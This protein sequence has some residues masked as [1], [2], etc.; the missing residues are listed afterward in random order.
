MNIKWLV[1]QQYKSF[2]N[3]SQPVKIAQIE[4]LE[5]RKPARAKVLKTDLV[6]IKYDDE[7]SV[8]YGR[9]LHRWVLLS[10]G[11]ISWH[12][13]ICGVHNR[14]YRMDTWVS[15]YNNDEVLHKFWIALH[16]NAVWIDQGEVES[17]ERT[18]PSPFND[19]EYLWE[20]Q[21][22]HPAP[23][24]PRIKYIQHLAKHGLTKRWH[25]WP[26]GA[27]GVSRELLP[28]RDSIQFLPGQFA[29]RPLMDDDEVSTKVV[30]G[31]NAKKPLVL[32]IP[33]FVSDMSFGALSK[34]SKIAL[35]RW[36]EAAWTGI[37]SGEW[38]MLPEEQAENSKYF[39]ELASWWF[40]FSRDKV[41]KCQAFHFKWW[42]WAKV[43]T[44]WHLPWDKVTEEIAAVRWLKEWEDAI[45]PPTFPEYKT[46]DDFKKLAEKAREVTWGAPIG[47]KLA[48][49]RIE[50]DIDFAL[51][52]GCDYIILDWRWG[53]T[54]AAPL[55]FRD[56]ISV[57]TIPAL[58]RARKYLDSRDDAK[59]VTLVI[60]WWLR[61][62]SDFVKALALWA[63]AIAVSNAALQAIGCIGMRACNTN[64]CP[65]WIA[66]QKDKL[67]E[68]IEI[69][70][71]AIQLKNFF[72]AST[73]LIQVVARACGHDDLNKFNI[74]DISTFDMDMHT[75]TWIAYAGVTL[76]K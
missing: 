45:S 71:S 13:L 57:P 47:F 69:G 61:V 67:R 24:E 14:D 31:P 28:K 41:A 40:W 55:I 63:D 26:A 34:E 65:V 50:Q 11:H 72:E 7:I 35:S 4:N 27:M 58:A 33:L 74:N 30:I 51:A 8:L 53:W 39:Y 76:D 56:H 2:D 23:E 42:Q 46:V 32:D 25:H 60:T 54:G 43:W 52:V 6:L 22:T 3:L 21:D 29:V 17:F 70:K 9:C 62:P 36:A 66:T 1:P 18:H 49:S 38:G 12:N 59:W 16:E 75:L 19:E 10:D 64:N 73:H 5:D 20:Y 15:E 44:W 37:C 68:R 48:A